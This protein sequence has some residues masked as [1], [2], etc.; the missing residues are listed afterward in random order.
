MVKGLI[1]TGF[2]ELASRQ[3]IDAV[4]K[5]ALGV[6]VERVSPEKKRA[7]EARDEAITDAATAEGKQ[8]TPWLK[9]DAARLE[10]CRPRRIKDGNQL[11]AEKCP[12][13]SRPSVG[14]IVLLKPP[15]SC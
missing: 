5:K 12:D 11:F 3:I 8:S 2:N 10:H 6:F 1:H 9:S 7:E 13:A 4:F 14:A 15:S